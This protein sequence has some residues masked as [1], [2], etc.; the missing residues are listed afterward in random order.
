MVPKRASAAT[1]SRSRFS[2]AIA[3]ASPS[4]S[5]ASTSSSTSSNASSASLKSISPST[6]SSILSSSFSMRPA[7]SR[8]CAT[9]IGHAEIAM[10]MCFRPSSIRLAISISPSRVRSSTEPISRM[11]IRTGSVVRPNSESSVDT[12]ASAASSTSS[13]GVV[14]AAS[15]ISSDSASGASSYTWMPMSPIML[16]M[17]SICSASSTSSGRWSLISANVRK[18]RSLP[19]T[20][21]VFSRRLRAS[22]SA[23]VSTRGAISAWRPLRPFLLAASSA[24][25]PAILAAISPAVG[26][27]AGAAATTGLPAAPFTGFTAAYDRLRVRLG[28][29]L[30]HRPGDDLVLRAPAWRPCSLGFLLFEHNFLLADGLPGFALPAG[31]REAWRAALCGAFLRSGF[32]GFFDAALRVASPR[33]FAPATFLAAGLRDLGCCR[34]FADGLR[35]LLGHG[36]PRKI[37]TECLARGG[38]RENLKLYHPVNRTAADIP[39][40]PCRESPR[41]HERRPVGCSGSPPG[42][43]WRTISSCR[44]RSFSSADVAATASGPTTTPARLACCQ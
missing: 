14:G 13:A 22:T 33:V 17:P 5:L 2:A 19:R 39:C 21:S 42:M 24:R 7:R 27:C 23:G 26:L 38:D 29:S 40:L 32:A 9:V 3:P 44:S 34:R 12:A 35:G 8:I 18:P 15:D 4:S 25:L 10:I 43:P 11:Y 16:T 28:T 30:T 41:R 6:R 31:L 20:I 36:H 37:D 1:F